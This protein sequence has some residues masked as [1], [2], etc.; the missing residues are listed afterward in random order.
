MVEV[1]DVREVCRSCDIWKK[2]CEG[3]KVGTGYNETGCSTLC[4]YEDIAVGRLEQVG[5]FTWQYKQEFQKDEQEDEQE[6]L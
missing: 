3:C 4:R 6:N 5:L 1:G 2:G